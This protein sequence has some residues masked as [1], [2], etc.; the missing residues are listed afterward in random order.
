MATLAELIAIE[1]ADTETVESSVTGNGTASLQDLIDI[2]NESYTAPTDK[3]VEGEFIPA[4]KSLAEKQLEEQGLEGTLQFGPFDSG[5]PL[6]DSLT[7]GLIGVGKGFDDVGRGLGFLD[8][9][10]DIEKQAFEKLKE[11][12]GVSAQVGEVIGQV[13]PFLAPGTAVGA[14][15]GLG[16]RIVAA[17]TLGLAEGG[18]LANGQE[19][20]L[21]EAVKT[22]GIGGLVAGGLEAVFPIVGRVGRQVFTRLRGR[23]PEGALL[24]I[25][26]KP[27]PEL[28]AVLDEAG[29]TF[30][31]LTEKAT[32]VIKNN[33]NA[34]PDDVVR[35]ARFGDLDIPA[36]GGDI[37]QDLSR[38]T[39]EA[40][41]NELPNDPNAAE[42]QAFRAR[43]S[44]AFKDNLDS[45][46]DQS[47]VSDKA[48]ESFKEVL[49]GQKELLRT[50]KNALYREFAESSPEV[51]SIPIITDTIADVLPS[52]KEIRRRAS[53]GA[54]LNDLLVEFGL[55]RDPKR[56]EKF[57]KQDDAEI[58]ILNI[59]NFDDFR[60]ELARLD[61]ADPSGAIGSITGPLRS[62]LDEEAEFVTEA[63]QKAGKTD[64]NLLAPLLEARA[65]VTKS[66]TEFDPNRLAGKLTSKKP[67]SREARVEASQVF[68]ETFGRKSVP[69]EQIDKLMKT[70][71]ES[72]GGAEAIGNMQARLVQDLIDSS[73]S[74]QSKKAAGENLFNANAFNR[75]IEQI[76]TDKIDSLFKNSPEA[77]KKLDQLSKAA[78]DTLPDARSV[79]KGSASVILDMLN[80]FGAVKVITN[81]PTIV[82][83]RAVAKLVKDKG[84]SELVLRKALDD[85]PALR[86]HVKTIQDDLPALA[87]TLGIAAFVVDGD[88]E[89]NENE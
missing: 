78:S 36:S 23:E 33:P 61:K 71:G 40:R 88:N 69:I 85:A 13:A 9:K 89:D 14:I 47:G 87:S 24:D 72:K 57:L 34:K 18:I 26:G 68:S 3:P 15:A 29:L 42:F 20:S 38:Q 44:Q 22:A 53:G 5:I 25:D 62:M 65:V 64:D 1:E 80:Q 75:R 4:E 8:G 60:K 59:G 31:D 66:K 74:T 17:T 32:R 58:E 81:N 73:F 50:E 54:E 77:R 63:L 2:E 27:T 79:P 49:A 30:A 41:L 37:T 86:E 7:A 56:I 48:G 39:D 28:V 55:D 43:Q 84:D 6:P 10:S 45:L 35:A 51:R 52:R 76:G 16:T 12:H 46:V 83:L 21:E 19:A 67:K 11:D 82:G 70:L